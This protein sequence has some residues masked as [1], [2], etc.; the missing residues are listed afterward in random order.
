MSDEPVIIDDATV[1]FTPGTQCAISFDGK[2]TN[3][4]LTALIKVFTEL[5]ATHPSLFRYE[6]D[7]HNGACVY[8]NPNACV[9]DKPT[10]TD[11]LYL[12]RKY[13][14]VTTNNPPPGS[15]SN[16]GPGAWL[17]ATVACSP[18][19]EDDSLCTAGALVPAVAPAFGSLLLSATFAC[20]L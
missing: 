3:A 15:N 2:G 5:I 8:L 6:V 11:H 14:L 9:C 1:P 4:D 7:K 12:P 16:A 17:E 19:K 10:F 13:T 18:P 20:A